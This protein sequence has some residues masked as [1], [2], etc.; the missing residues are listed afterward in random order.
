MCAAVTTVT[1]AELGL[2]CRNGDI[3]LRASGNRRGLSLDAEIRCSGDDSMGRR[4]PREGDGDKR[5]SQKP[6]NESQHLIKR[7]SFA[8]AVKRDNRHRTDW[9]AV[10]YAVH[11]CFRRLCPIYRSNLAL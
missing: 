5:Q 7:L 6:V 11:A 1:G 4:S 3:A 10:A 8:P 9:Q 2:L